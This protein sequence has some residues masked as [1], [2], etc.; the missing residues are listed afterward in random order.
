M[1]NLCLWAKSE[2]ISCSVD[3]SRGEMARPGATLISF[4]AMSSMIKY[5]VRLGFLCNRSGP[6][7]TE[8]TRLVELDLFL[9]GWYRAENK[10]GKTTD[11]G[12]LT[13]YVADASSDSHAVTRLTWAE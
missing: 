5:L 8:N 10:R 12:R 7:N 6:G 9:Y 11:Y 13:I 2:K 1:K 3:L 4:V